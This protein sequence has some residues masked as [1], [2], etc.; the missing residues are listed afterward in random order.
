MPKNIDPQVA[1][2]VQPVARNRIELKKDR[3]TLLVGGPGG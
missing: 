2:Y 1:K 3:Y